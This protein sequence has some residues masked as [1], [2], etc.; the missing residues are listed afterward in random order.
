VSEFDR[1]ILVA[2]EGIDG[3]GKTTQVSLLRDALRRAG[4]SVVV[5]KEPTNGEWGQLIRDSA[6][7]GRLSLERELDL[8]IRDRTQHVAEVIKPALETGNIVI[9]DRYFYSTIAYQGSRGAN[10]ADLNAHMRSL[11]PLPDAV[12]IL[13]LDPILSL[14]RIAYSRGEEPNHFEE[15]EGLERARSIFNGLGSSEITTVDG[16]MSSLSVHRTIL[17]AFINGALKE[18]RCAKSYGC[19]DPFH[20]CFRLTQNCEWVRIAA[21]LKKAVEQSPVC[22]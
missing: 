2:V 3:A 13:D 5:S 9:L 16:S 15:R 19:N 11:F 18:K 8:F 22:A 17:D 7:S 4:E 10:V 20:C 6:S 21:Q 14:H 1:S 12:F